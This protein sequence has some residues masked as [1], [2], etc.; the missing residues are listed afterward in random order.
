MKRGAEESLSL[1]NYNINEQRIVKGGR[2]ESWTKEEL[3]Q[4]VKRAGQTSD[5]VGFFSTSRYISYTMLA[6]LRSPDVGNKQ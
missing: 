6:A 3:E 5:G 1:Q 4:G 2:K